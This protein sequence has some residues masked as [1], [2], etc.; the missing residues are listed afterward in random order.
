MG[1]LAGVEGTL[2]QIFISEEL[3][4]SR[5]AGMVGIQ[6]TDQGRGIDVGVRNRMTH[7]DSS[8]RMDSRTWEGLP[9]TSMGP[10][11]SMRGAISA[12][13][14]SRMVLAFNRTAEGTT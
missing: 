6:G 9:F 4:D 7:R 2:Q 14:A 10:S 5:G 8:S 13:L 1:Q 3:L 12:S 11:N